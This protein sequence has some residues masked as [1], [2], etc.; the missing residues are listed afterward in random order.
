MDDVEATHLAYEWHAE[1]GTYQIGVPN[2][3]GK[4][5]LGKSYLNQLHQSN[6]RRP[7]SI[8]T[9]VRLASAMKQEQSMNQPLDAQGVG[10]NTPLMI[11]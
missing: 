4:D 1:V 6:L 10:N 8:K 3:S 11:L 7:K 5:D 2:V 9:S